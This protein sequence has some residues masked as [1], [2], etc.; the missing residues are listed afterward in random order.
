MEKIKI[1][2]SSTVKDLRKERSIIKKT[3]DELNYSYFLNEY[4]SSRTGS[5]INVCLEEIKSCDIFLLV[6]G[7]RYGE[8]FPKV[9]E[10]D[11]SPYDGT[12]SI[13]H[14]EFLVGRELGKPIIVFVK[15]M[16]PF[17][18]DKREEEFLNSLSTFL[19]GQFSTE[20]K[21]TE[22]LRIK[23]K[24]SLS[25]VLASMIRYKYS[26]PWKKRFNIIIANDEEEVAKIGAKILAFTIKKR[27]NANIGLSAGRTARDMFFQF[28]KEYTADQMKNIISTRFFSVTEHFGISR[29]NP[30]SYYSWFNEAFFSKVLSEWNLNIPDENK[31]LVPSVIDNNTLEGFGI[32]YDQFLQIHK[33]DVQFI[34]P[35]PDGQIICID[36][37]F[38][39]IEQMK[40]MGTRLVIYSEKTSKY[41]VPICPHTMDIVIGIRNLLTRSERLV[42]LASGKNK[43][44][45]VR[46]MILGPV[47]NKWPASLVYLYPNEKK[48]FFV[49]DK[50]I[51]QEIPLDRSRYNNIIKSEDFIKPEI[52]ESYW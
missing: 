41:L 23:V 6:I 48:L 15:D 52:F 42:I 11:L 9:G 18:R 17:T 44:E 5:P 13:T 19:D 27:P 47:S 22:E 30:N 33:V 46:R 3:L 31:M 4:E 2:V 35:A 34:S 24:E 45:V 25:N 43:I 1:F 26:L 36:P 51:A 37:E 20:F 50:D 28:F 16:P 8:E 29:D 21:T 40:N 7:E 14:G 12:I 49:L 32:Q 39:S 10:T 38:C